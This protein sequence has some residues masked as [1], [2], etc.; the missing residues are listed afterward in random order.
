M[1]RTLWFAILCGSVFAGCGTFVD[2]TP[3][4]ESPR[5]LSPRALGSVEVFS[6]GAPTRPHVDVALVEAVQTH[7]LNEQGTGLMV[8]RMR[9]QAAAMGCD[10]IVLGGATDHQGAPPGSGWDLLDPGATKRQATCIVYEDST[11]VHPF[12]TAPQRVAATPAR[13]DVVRQHEDQEAPR[14]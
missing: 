14:D 1:R 12:R 3:L 10:A 8:Q 9:E 11:S 4:N 7:S 6:S 2:F 5:P 13:E